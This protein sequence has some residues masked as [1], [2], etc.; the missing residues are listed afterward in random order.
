MPPFV[1]IDGKCSPLKFVGQ[2][3]LSLHQEK[4]CFSFCTRFHHLTLVEAKERLRFILRNALSTFT[5]KCIIPFHIMPAWSACS[6]NYS[7][8]RTF[9]WLHAGPQVSALLLD[10]H[11]HPLASHPKVPQGRQW[12]A[13][14][15]APAFPVADRQTWKKQRMCASCRPA[16]I[17][18]HAFTETME[19]ASDFRW[20]H[21]SPW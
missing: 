17:Q 13:S 19:V 4:C 9:E 15:L 6:Q 3:Q 18:R 20:T 8:I 1:W 7:C 21:R 14:Q 10:P 2:E 16:G 11:L 5:N 12:E